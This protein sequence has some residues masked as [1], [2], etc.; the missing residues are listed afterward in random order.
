MLEDNQSHGLTET[1]VAF[2]GGALFGAGLDTV[3]CCSV[4][5]KD[6]RL[7]SEAKDFYLD[8]HGAC[9]SCIFPRGAS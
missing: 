1:E 8:M 9:G 6:M 4:A 3:K 2:L 5:S 7:K